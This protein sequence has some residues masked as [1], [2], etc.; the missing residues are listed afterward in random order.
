MVLK[1]NRDY[2]RHQTWNGFEF[3]SRFS[4]IQSKLCKIWKVFQLLHDSGEF[5][6]F[7]IL[8][9]HGQFE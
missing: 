8:S 1:Q 6:L 9:C 5:L 7:T 3:H 2:V 4:E